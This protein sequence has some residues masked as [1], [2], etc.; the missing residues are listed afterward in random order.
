MTQSSRAWAL[1]PIKSFGDAK[2]R[3]AEAVDARTRH[4]LV[5][6]MA[7]DVIAQLK[8]VPGLAGILIATR[9]DEVRGF[10]KAQQV[11]CWEE[12]RD[13]D[14]SA[15]LNAAARHLASA[16]AADTVMILPCDVPLVESRLLSEALSRH[17]ALTLASDDGGEGTNL[18]I[19]SPPNLIEFCY[20]GHGFEVHRGRG[21][22]L[23]VDV[24]IIEDD[25]IQLDVD[26]PRDL[27]R[28]TKRAIGREGSR[29]LNLISQ[30]RARFRVPS[31]PVEKV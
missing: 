12:P 5:R 10:A 16:L 27:D 6:T 23:G 8:K 26:T 21:L 7:E 1:V 2:K 4:L 28:L 18:L 13:A 19:A 11:E 20:D 15:A 17:Q 25:T 24:Q 14:L 30:N 22:A 31:N 9:S 3:L 29:T